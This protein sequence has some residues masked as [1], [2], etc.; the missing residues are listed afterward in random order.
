VPGAGTAEEEEEGASQS[1]RG[2]GGAPKRTRSAA[3]HC[4]CAR[5]PSTSFMKSGALAA[6]RWLFSSCN[7]MPTALPNFSSLF[8]AIAASARATAGRPRLSV[9]PSPPRPL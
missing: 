8:M 2:W 9:P 4:R 7:T 1:E 6:V 5:A 3:H